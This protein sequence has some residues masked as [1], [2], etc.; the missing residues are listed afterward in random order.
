MLLVE[1]DVPLQELE[2][3]WRRAAGSG[4]FVLVSG[5]A[6]IG[7]TALVDAFA[8]RYQ[9]RARLLWGACDALFTPR[10]L[11]PLHDMAAQ[12]AGELPDLL[13]AEAN[14][15]LIFLASLQALQQQ[16]ALAVIEDVHWADEAT[17]DLLKYLGRR[18]HLTQSLLLLTFRDDELP[19]QHPLRLLLGD[20]ATSPAVRRI[21]LRPLSVEGVQRLSEQQPQ[22]AEAL[23]RQTGGNPFFVTEVLA[24]GEEG[25]PATVRDA[26]LARA[27][28]L[29]LSGRAVLNAAAVI[30]PRIEPWLLAAVVRAEAG[31]VSECLH[32][33]MLQAPGEM[34]AFRHQLAQQVILETIPAH[35][36]I[37]LHQA[38][39]D[40]LKLSPRTQTDVARLAHHA[41]AAN[42][43]EEILAFA[44]AAGREAAALGMQRAAA[45]LFALA[46]RHAEN[47]PLI[48]QIELHE[49]YALSTQGEPKRE[50]TIA[51]R[52]RAA[53]LARA[54]N[55][56]LREGY[57]LAVLSNLLEMVD[58]QEESDSVLYEALALLEPLAPNRGL[59][60][61][62][63][64]LAYRH[65]KRGESEMAVA[66]AEKSQQVAQWTE[67]MPVIIAAYHMLALCWLP[68]DHQRGCSFLEKT[69][70]LALEHN[71]FWTAGAAYPNL[72]MTYV[73]VYKLE[74]AEQLATEG[75]AFTTEHD[76]DIARQVLEGWQA[77]IA[78]L[79]G[80]WAEARTVAANLLRRPAV[81]PY[82]RTPSRLVEGRLRARQGDEPGAESMLDEALAGLLKTNNRQR[83]PT[84]YT[85]RAEAAWLAG[86]RE[87]T[88]AEAK[89]LQDELTEQ[90]R[91]PGFAAELAYWRWRAGEDVEVADWMV[92]PFVLE[93]QGNWQ[94]ASAEW[95]RLGCPYEQARA[96]ADGDVE[97][98]KAALLIFEELG[99][100][101]MVEQVR[102]KLRAA[103][104]Q[105]IP[106]G[107]RPA[108]RDNPFGLTNRQLDVLALLT[109]NLTNAEIAGR[110]H[111]SPKTVDHHVSA[112]LGKLAVS[113]REEAAAL[114]RELP[115]F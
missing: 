78:L 97:A 101:P 18:I 55:L 39:L 106:R 61:V 89:A 92:D 74:R 34:L 76:M 98:R 82:A 81:H 62:Y 102:Q 28:R 35:Q 77:M 67:E 42:N 56:P 29:S 58:A 6:G 64:N 91:Q 83:L 44:P 20:L 86:D 100:R 37:F 108:T 22:R 79:R 31:A 26:V 53:E 71:D 33:G 80:R 30:G 46:L 85:A 99:A 14:R 15:S 5:E 52:R 73:D 72:T 105:V 69:L 48:Q 95:E 94:A 65:L 7:K 1:R 113:S 111:I 13:K 110:L 12:L 63:K 49:A 19:P 43:R 27:A 84:A 3:A 36:R 17:L 103:G 16:P 90:N 59:V 75:I 60:D 70:Q 23:H 25:V 45:S 87:R 88:L 107:P 2:V 4:C 32:V 68:L 40:E 104:V 47:L 10:P 11:G 24:A 57:N 54:A 51:A 50:A 96:L 115:G 21:A 93:I 9:G 112:I 66:Y 109:D 8:R 41:Q 114:A 38:V